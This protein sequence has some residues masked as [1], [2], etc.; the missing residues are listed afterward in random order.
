MDQRRGNQGGSYIAAANKWDEA[1]A[2]RM[3]PSEKRLTDQLIDARNQRDRAIAR[4]EYAEAMLLGIAEDPWLAEIKERIRLRAAKATGI[5]PPEVDETLGDLVYLVGLVE[6]KALSLRK[7]L[8][9]D[10]EAAPAAK[11]GERL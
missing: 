6:R 2:A 9:S 7:R 5:N 11:P 3:S 1:A 8:G 4:Q 10:Q